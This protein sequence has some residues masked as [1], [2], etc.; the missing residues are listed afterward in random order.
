MRVNKLQDET[1]N[2]ALCLVFRRGAKQYSTVKSVI[3]GTS[4]TKGLPD[5]AAFRISEYYT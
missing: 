1:Q 2:F 3:S 5:I 4:G